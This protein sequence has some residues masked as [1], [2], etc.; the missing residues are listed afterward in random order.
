MVMFC[1]ESSVVV[2]YCVLDEAHFIVLMC[3]LS[4]CFCVLHTVRV[5]NTEEPGYQVEAI[6]AT[7]QRTQS[8]LPLTVCCVRMRL[9]LLQ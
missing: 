1:T 8:E 3:S 5:N 9:F 4:V 7:T 2:S 6:E